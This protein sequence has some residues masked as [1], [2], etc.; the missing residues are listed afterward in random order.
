MNRYQIVVQIEDANG[1]THT[2]P[3]GQE[4]NEFTALIPLRNTLNSTAREGVRY[5]VSA[6]YADLLAGS[7]TA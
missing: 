1:A 5:Q 4:A 3:I 7:V 2:W 6:T